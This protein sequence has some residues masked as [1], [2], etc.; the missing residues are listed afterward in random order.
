MSSI[1]VLGKGGQVANAFETLLGSRALV[2]GADEA[3]FLSKDFIERLE[4]W[5]GKQPLFAVINAAAYT[6]VD[7][8]EGEDRAKSFRI[9]A[10]AVGELAAWCKKRS[11]PLVHYSTDY[12]FDGSGSAPRREDE[13][14]GPL[15]AYGDS[16]LAG[17]KALTE[18]GGDYLLFR[19]SWLYDSEGKNFFNTM[20]RLMREKDTLSVVS[21][22]IGAPTY[23]PH[24]AKATLFALES[25]AAMPQFSTGT[26]H[27]CASGETSWHGFAQAIFERLKS[28]EPAIVCQKILPVPSSAYPLP[29]RRPLNSRLDCTRAQNVLGVALPSWKKGLEECFSEILKLDH[30]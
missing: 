13:P 6:Q 28:V 19:T 30:A 17:E 1:L 7:K 8:A 26:Y 24:L 21:D 5:V 3:D 29:A 16:K 10:E 25:A 22:Q 9:N 15:N 12:V 11:L 27:L 18:H 14:T 20:R 4:N 23:A 2:A